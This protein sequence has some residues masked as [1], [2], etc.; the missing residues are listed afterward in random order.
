MFH[1]VIGYR[2]VFVPPLGMGW[3]YRKGTKQQLQ[4][5]FLR[6]RPGY[7]KVQL[8]SFAVAM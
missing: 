5:A 6:G 2:S 8:D 3:R 1:Q 7:Q 4:L